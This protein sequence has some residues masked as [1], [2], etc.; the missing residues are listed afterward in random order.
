MKTRSVLILTLSVLVLVL[1][2]PF[3]TSRAEVEA[4]VRYIDVEVINYIENYNYFKT[5]TADVT[6]FTYTFALWKINQ[7]GDQIYFTAYV[8]KESI[9]DVVANWSVTLDADGQYISAWIDWENSDLI[10][11]KIDFSQFPLNTTTLT[12]PIDGT[13]DYKFYRMHFLFKGN[14]EVGEKVT[15][16]GDY[17]VPPNIENTTQPSPTPTLS[18]SPSVTPSPSATPTESPSPT[19]SITPSPTPEPTSSTIP[20]TS[21][22]QNIKSSGNQLDR[23]GNLAAISNH[24]V[25]STGSSIDLEITSTPPANESG[26]VEFRVLNEPEPTPSPSPTTTLSP[27]TSPTHT[28]SP[29]S[30]TSPSPTAKPTSS[31]SITSSPNP[32]SIQTQPPT[33]KPTPTS[34][35]GDRNAPHLE[36]TDY[37]LPISIIFAIIL[38]SVL[39]FRRHQKTANL[40][41]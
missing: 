6:N 26:T 33:P 8:E 15:V 31:N 32:T 5:V 34:P 24:V 13:Q 17:G 36:L 41:Q 22:Q 28:V 7:E 9:V 40:K 11:C 38:F 30:S 18:P 35:Q 10:E 29:L 23:I 39:L 16:A 27:S 3:I 4:S 19:V 20:S 1:T 21:P 25:S 37:L 14:L 12:H 2:A